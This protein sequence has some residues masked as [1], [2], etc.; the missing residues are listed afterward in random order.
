MKTYHIKWHNIVKNAEK[1]LTE[2]LLI[3]SETVAA[4]LQLEVDQSID[5][6]FIDESQDLRTAL[7]KKNREMK[8]QL[9]K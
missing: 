1:Q 8:K 7:E 3:V 5:A 6:L 4:K 9:E 2:L